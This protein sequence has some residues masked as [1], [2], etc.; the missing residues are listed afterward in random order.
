MPTK[1]PQDHKKKAVKRVQA[2]A[3]QQADI[4]D[5]LGRE[6][7]VEGRVGTAVVTVLEDPMEWDARADE[8]LAGWS[9]V[10]SIVVGEMIPFLKCIVSLEDGRVLDT[11]R[12]SRKSVESLIELLT[13]NEVGE[14]LGDELG[15]SAAS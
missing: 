1:Q 7:E 8:I 11:I 5:F 3:R 12:P 13:G 6:I 15:E 10:G 4:S 2:E 9:S 14:S